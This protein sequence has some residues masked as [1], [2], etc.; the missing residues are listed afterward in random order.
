MDAG[1]QPQGDAGHV[2]NA[3]A[4]LDRDGHVI[5]DR[6]HGAGIHR[7]AGEGAVQVHHM[8]PGKSGGLPGL[9]LGA[10]IVGVDRRLRH[11]AAA[12]ADTFAVLQVDRRIDRQTASRRPGHWPVTALRGR[13]RL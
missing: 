7:P 3:A 4:Q 9:R 5:Q 2:A 8:Q 6:L 10:G 13:S 1:L 12:Q 11:I